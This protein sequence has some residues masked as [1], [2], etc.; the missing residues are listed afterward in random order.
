MATLLGVGIIGYICLQIATDRTASADDKKWATAILTS[1][2]TGG[3]GYL[4]GK[5]KK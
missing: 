1:T 4:T 5:A 3:I 2:V